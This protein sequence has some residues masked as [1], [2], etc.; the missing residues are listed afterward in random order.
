M[1]RPKQL[2]SF[3]GTTLLRRAAQTAL[4][5]PCRP[6]VAVLGAAAAESARELAGL[7][8]HTFENSNWRAGMGS[9]I[10]AGLRRATELDPVLDAVLLML[11]DQPLIGPP[12][13]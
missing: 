9:T 1:G 12:D 5:T 2:L 4:A 10:K 3:E 8:V 11:C 13:L 7:D 6:V